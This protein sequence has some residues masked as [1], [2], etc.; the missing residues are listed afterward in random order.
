MNAA[1]HHAVLPGDGLARQPWE[2]FDPADVQAVQPIVER[3]GYLGE[4]FQVLANVPGATPAFLDYAKVL[5]G[6]LGD[7]RTELIALAVCGAMDASYER[8]QHER[9]A[10]RLGLGLDWIAAASQRPGADPAALDAADRRVL[11]LALA[12]AGV[13]WD[14]A[15]QCC[16]ELARHDGAAVATAALVQATRY[17]S[18]ASLCHTLQLTLPVGSVFA[19]ADNA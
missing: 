18:I 17:V 11:A 15:R 7:R 14:E 19:A 2:R 16:A 4:F 12:V 6:A 13:R 9:L 1:T 5:K 10:Q 8:I 3:L